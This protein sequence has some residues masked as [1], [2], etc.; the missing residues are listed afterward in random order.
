MTKV[1]MATVTID[2]V[3]YETDQLSEDARAQLTSVQAVDRKLAELQAEAAMLQTARVAY[4]AALKQALGA[5][6]AVSE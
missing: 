4:F 5:D 3:D 6:N 1:R 2:G